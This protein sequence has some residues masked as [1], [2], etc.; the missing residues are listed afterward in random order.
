MNEVK[1]C[2]I[3]LANRHY[4]GLNIRIAVIK[5]D[6]CNKKEQKISGISFVSMFLYRIMSSLNDAG[7]VRDV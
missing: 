1:I 4:L 5:F 6:D 7:F 2:G 3:L